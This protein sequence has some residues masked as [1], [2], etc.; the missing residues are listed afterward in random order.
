MD[1]E[2]YSKMSDFFACEF[3]VLFFWCKVN[4]LVKSNIVWGIMVVNNVFYKLMDENECW[5]IRGREWKCLFIVSG[6]I[7]GG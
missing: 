4:V 7:K 1:D 6:N 5:K 2:V 3:I